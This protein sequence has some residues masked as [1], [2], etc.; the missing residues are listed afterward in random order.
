MDDRGAPR[1]GGRAATRLDANARLTALAL[2]L[3]LA[4]G[5]SSVDEVPFG[6]GG[7]GVG[8]GVGAAGG[9]GATGGAGA[10]GGTGGAGAALYVAP[11]VDD[12]DEDGQDDWAVSAGQLDDELVSWRLPTDWTAAVGASDTVRLTLGGD[13][14]DFRLWRDGQ[15]ILGAPAEGAPLTEVRLGREELGAGLAVELRTFRRHGTLHIDQLGPDDEL[16]A[17]WAMDLW[18]A[19]LVLGHHGQ[20]AER[21]YVVQT[22]SNDELVSLLAELAGNR[23]TVVDS[24][25]PWMQ[26]ELE[27]ATSTEPAHR[28]DIA[29]DSIRDRELDSWV[30]SLAAP[31]VQPMTWGQSEEATTE[32]KFGN[33]ETTPAYTGGG[34]SYPLGRVYFGD[35]GVVGP[36]ESLQAML[37]DQLVQPPLRIDTSWLCIGHVDEL[38]TFVPA[39]ASSKGFVLLIADVPAGYELLEAMEPSVQLTHYAFSHGYASPAELVG[40]AALRALNEDV[41]ADYLDPIRAE[42]TSALELDPEDVVRVPALFERLYGCPYSSSPMEVVA[43]VPALVNLAVVNPEGQAPALVV[44]DPFLRADGEGQGADPLIAAFRAAMPVGVDTHFVDSWFSYHVSW[45]D[46]HCGTSVRRT[47]TPAWYDSA[48]HLLGGG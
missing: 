40:D 46:V 43:L 18:G 15:V 8:G 44:P 27:W 45:G 39:P 34:T 25:D 36:N 30:K 5:C 23:L 7:G 13:V 22:G 20:S 1:P 28:L 47:P 31:N 19:P 14:A 37:D 3:L 42:L 33:L 48:M 4:S 16:R 9:S 11:N 12:D 35:D 29:V 10:G 38:M 17:S 24:S 21:V 2:G 32:D 6:D 41:Q 26:D